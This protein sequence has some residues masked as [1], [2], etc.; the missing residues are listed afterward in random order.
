MKE[1]KTHTR[2]RKLLSGGGARAGQ[3]EEK[4]PVTR[5]VA[6]EKKREREVELS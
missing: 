2:G 1:K 4:R 5:V 3:K 6:Q